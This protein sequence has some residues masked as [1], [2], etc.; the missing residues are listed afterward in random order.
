MAENITETARL[1]VVSRES[2]LLP[3]LWSICESNSWQMETAASAWDAIERMQSGPVPDLLLLDL[4]RGDGDGQHILR[5]LRRIHPSLRVIV[6]CFAEDADRNDEALRLGAEELIVKPLDDAQLEWAIQHH[7]VSSDDGNGEIGNGDIEQLG[8]DSYFVCASPVSQ[9][10]RTQVQLLADSDVPV[11]ILGEAGSGKDTVARLIHKL[12]IRSSFNF[13]KVNCAN[14]PAELLD[15]ELFGTAVPG[16]GR[17]GTGKLERADKGTIFFDEITDMPLSIQGRLM[18]QLH[19]NMQNTAAVAKGS[20]FDCR[21]VAATSANLDRALAERRLREDLYYWL[22]AFTVQVPPLWHRKNEIGVLMQHL[23]HRLSKQYGLPPRTFSPAIL[24][25]CRNYSWPG[26]LKE[27]ESFVKRYL[28]VGDKDLAFHG[29]RPEPGKTNGQTGHT[30]HKTINNQQREAEHENDL[31][32]ESGP[33]S[34]KSLVDS[35]KSEA[36][37]NAIGLALQK[38]RW[39]RKA[40]A[41]LLK[42]SYRTLLYKIDQYHMRASES[43]LSPLPEDLSFGVTPKANEKNGRAAS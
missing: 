30:N 34:L 41:R 8:P 24:N 3:P 23:M 37:R 28:V 17:M 5:W 35:V 40:A 29:I 43:F 31:G 12:S 2:T 7:L 26:N 33:I 4:P 18:H 15:A 20:S 27:L 1:L 13:V 32:H 39:N 9:K 10:L 22:S 19:N 21:I 38:T 6:L 16:D 11:L 36:E 14:M 25:S 42:V